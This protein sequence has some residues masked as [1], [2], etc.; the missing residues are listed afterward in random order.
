MSMSKKDF[1]ALADELKG[2]EVSPEVVD[3]L[4]RF[5]R[6]QNYAFKEDRWREYLAG[7]CGPSGGPVKLECEQALSFPTLPHYKL[8]HKV[9]VDREPM[10]LCTKC[11]DRAKANGMEV[12]LT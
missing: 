10:V 8:G 5:M 7:Q 12:S 4:C 6:R 3:A 11:C 1:I 9:L 2:L